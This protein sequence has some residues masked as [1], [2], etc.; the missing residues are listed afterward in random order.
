M[1]PI[2]TPPFPISISSSSTFTPHG[3]ATAI[4]SRLSGYPT[5]KIF[6]HGVPTD[7]HGPRKSDLL[8][9]FL[10]KFVAPDVAVLTSDSA[11]RG[12]IKAADS[13]FPV[14]IGFGLNESTILDL[15]IKYKKNAWFSVAKDFSHEIMAVYKFDKVPALVAIHPAYNELSTFY[16]QFEEKFLEDYIKQNLLPLILPI[17]QDSLKLLKDDPRKILITIMEDE[18]EEKSKRVLEVLKAAASE[19]RDLIFGYAGFKQW[20]EFAES[21][22]VDKKTKL[23]KIVVWDGNEEY[24]SVIG[25][26]SIDETDMGSH[27]SRFLEGYRG[28]NVIKKCITGPTLM[29]FIK[30]QLGVI[31]ILV[32]ISV[33]LVVVLVVSM[34]NEEPHSVGSREHVVEGWSPTHHP[35]TR[36]LHGS[37]KED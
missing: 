35:E 29:S 25:S 31:I 8:V 13:D 33:V 23:P 26:E 9:R 30:S 14:F 21:F 32:I 36:K 20:E 27:M 10:T 16:G 2:S 19:N 7:Y 18:T 37:V 1:I 15:A 24:Y 12:F 22:E 3:V 11:I 34:T 17:S 6:I 5:L 28:G 4:V